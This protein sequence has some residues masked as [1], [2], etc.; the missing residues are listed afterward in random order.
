[1]RKLL[2]AYGT[3]VEDAT[4]EWFCRH[5]AN[6]RPSKKSRER[7]AIAS[8]EERTIVVATDEAP[9]EEGGVDEEDSEDPDD[10]SKDGDFNPKT[11]EDSEDTNEDST[12]RNYNLKTTHRDGSRNNKQRRTSRG[13]GN[14]SRLLK[15]KNT[16][17]QQIST[18]L[19][20]A[21]S[22]SV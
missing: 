17:K 13:S 4:S 21:K 3:K 19:Q 22:L 15:Q 16:S 7:H 8:S 11:D 6:L 20:T 12:D 9:A 5:V 10:D 14:P 1:L 2:K 18:P